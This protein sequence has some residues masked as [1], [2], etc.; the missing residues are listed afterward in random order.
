MSRQDGVLF[1]KL[2][3]A[4]GRERVLSRD[5]EG[6]PGEAVRSGELGGEKEREEELGFAN[7]AMEKSWLFAR[8]WA[9]GQGGKGA[10]LSP[11]TSVR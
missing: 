10:Y 2:A 3:Q 1:Q 9:N 11:V 6:R 8:I 4:R 7:T 5:I